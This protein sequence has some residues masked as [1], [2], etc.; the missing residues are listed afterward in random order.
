MCGRKTRSK[1]NMPTVKLHLD[2]DDSRKDL[3]EALVSRGHD[4]TRTPSRDLP[5]DAS[6][7]YQLLW[8]T[9]Q[10]RVIFTHNIS[11]FIQLAEKYSNHSG[12]I[13]ASQNSYSL[14]QLITLLDRALTAGAGEEF[15]GRVRWLSDWK[16]A[17]KY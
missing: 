3:L 5:E 8:A 13:L 4:V 6:D 10:G 11:D 2:A 17:D 14:S 15:R 1:N 7:E 9:A 12:I 16:M